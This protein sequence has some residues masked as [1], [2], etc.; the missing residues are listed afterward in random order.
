MRFAEKRV[1]VG[2][3]AYFARLYDANY[4]DAQEHDRPGQVIF[5]DGARVTLEA[6]IAEYPAE[7]HD[8]LRRVLS[9][10][11]WWKPDRSICLTSSTDTVQKHIKLRNRPH[12]SVEIM[13]HRFRLID[14][15]FRRLAER[16]PRVMI[17]NRDNMEFH[18]RAHL[19]KIIEAAGLPP[20]EE[21][22]YEV[23]EK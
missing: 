13:V 15:E 5:F 10:G 3:L 18:E 17:I 14:A 22:A 16:D 6:H 2:V 20:F 9:L 8:T 4:R 7:Q 21:I 1:A 19:L 23:V 12:E 11:D